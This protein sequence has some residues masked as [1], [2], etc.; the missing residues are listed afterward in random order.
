M[1]GAQESSRIIPVSLDYGIV[2]VNS[3]IKYNLENEIIIISEN[4][5]EQLKKKRIYKVCY[6]AYISG[7]NLSPIHY[8]Y[9]VLYNSL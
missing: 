4:K 7:S 8:V 5:C 1:W 6:L 9:E 3:Y 2:Q